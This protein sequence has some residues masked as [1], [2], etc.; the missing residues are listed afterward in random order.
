MF[1]TYILSLADFAACILL[2]DT[3]SAS[4]FLF[5]GGYLRHNWMQYSFAFLVCYTAPSL[6][7][8][9]TRMEIYTLIPGF[10]RK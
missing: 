9:D 2:V 7:V 5:R 4:A 3:A 8:H 10:W 6:D 1:V